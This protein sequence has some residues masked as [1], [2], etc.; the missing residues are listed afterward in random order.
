MSTPTPAVDGGAPASPRRA[1]L[2]GTGLIG[3]SVGLALRERGWHVTGTDLD[4]ARS[5]R[6]LEVGVIDQLGVDPHAE[7]TFV[8]VPVSAVPSAAAA[9]LAGGGVVTDVGSVKAP[10][11]AAANHPRFVGGHPMAGSEAIGVDGARA[12]LFDG[13]AWVLTPTASTDQ[14]ALA[15][16]HSVVRSFGADVLTLAPDQHDRLVATVSHVPHLTA[17][18]LMGLA[19]ARAESDTALLRLAAGGFRDMTRIAAGDP[20]MWLDVCAEN[21][22]A[23][24]E[25]IDE[26]SGSLGALRRVVADGDPDGLEALLRDAQTARRS[27]PTGAPPAEQLAEVRVQIPDKPGELAAITALATAR[28]INVHD[29]EVA[30][31]AEE[32]GGRLILVVDAAR[33]AELVD[34][35]AAGERVASAHEL[36]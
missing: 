24:L 31:S 3:A 29:I 28:G 16:V 34:V 7:V 26:L 17:A 36:T 2:V 21:R 35:L 11:V 25:V 30:H 14:D 19:T 15:L 32:R 22:D 33:A 27:L 18:A 1:G 10:V 12:D 8:A 20:A 6:A 5:A 4:P 23:I 13:A 9:A